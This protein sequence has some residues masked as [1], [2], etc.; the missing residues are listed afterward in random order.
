MSSVSATTRQMASPTQRVM[1][2]LAMNT[3]QSCWM[4]PTLLLGTSSAVRTA[5]TPGRARA[6][7]ASM[8]S[9]RA[10]GYWERTAEAWTMPSI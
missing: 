7:L 2:P 8:S 5:S 4:W 6:A 10:R 1:S 9:T 3:S